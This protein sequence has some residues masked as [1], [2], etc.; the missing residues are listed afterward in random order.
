MTGSLRLWILAAALAI[1]AGIGWALWRA[2]QTVELPS[3]TA[4]ESAPGIGTVLPPPTVAPP[5]LAASPP[6]GVSAEQWRALQQELAGQP[7]E[8]RRLDAYFRY[9]DQ[10]Q[11]FRA[12]P[13]TPSAERLALAR[14]LDEGLDERLRQRE[15]S[16]GEA[17]LVK[18]AVLEQLLPD[19]TQ[20][21]AALARWEQ[22]SAAAMPPAS[23]HLAAEA[24]HQRRQAALVAAW[25]ARPPAQR[26]P[27]AL[28]QALDALRQASFGAA[29]EG[30][31]R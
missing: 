2:P 28:E 25:S 16:A 3:A 5:I 31:L 30:G 15:V 4:P 14:A 10:M 22:D 21:L 17:R 13:R 20:R 7:A 26:D 29:P 24:E 12:L 27:Q 1:A 23:S 19:E 9:A 8:L 6:P 18:I 11:R